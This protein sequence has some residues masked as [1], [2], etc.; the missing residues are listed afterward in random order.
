MR[1]YSKRSGRI[2]PRRS[3][4]LSKVGVPVNFH[5]L[6]QFL[7]RKIPQTICRFVQVFPT[8]ELLICVSVKVINDEVS[9]SPCRVG[10]R[11]LAPS[12][13]DAKTNDGEHDYE[14]DDE[15]KQ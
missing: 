11:N 5:M 2:I 6:A 3:Q 14:D 12:A 7:D 13:E 15:R 1:D 9:G 4:Q 8:S 10:L